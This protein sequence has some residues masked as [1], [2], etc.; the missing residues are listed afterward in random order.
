LDAVRRIAPAP[1]RGARGPLRWLNKI[2]RWSKEGC[3]KAVVLQFRYFL[4]AVAVVQKDTLCEGIS[5]ATLSK[6]ELLARR[7]PRVSL[8]RASV[9]TEK[10]RSGSII[11]HFKD[12]VPKEGGAQ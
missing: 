4:D 7:E 2:K 10:M 3:A 12:Q 1:T 8:G 5:W 9:S 6:L 11:A